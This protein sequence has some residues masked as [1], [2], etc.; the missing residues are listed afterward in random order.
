MK[1]WPL[2]IFAKNFCE[3]GRQFFRRLRR[4]FPP[5]AEN[6][7]K[8]LPLGK[9]IRRRRKSTKIENFFKIFENGAL[10]PYSAKSI[11]DH[12]SLPRNVWKLSFIRNLHRLQIGS[13]LMITSA[14]TS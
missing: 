6:L 7:G 12:F 11:I 3:N 13:P 10:C 14:K 8:I 1:N 2:K 5:E 9:K 4:T